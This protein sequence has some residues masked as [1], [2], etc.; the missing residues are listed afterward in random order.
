MSPISTHDKK[1]VNC[2]WRAFGSMEASPVD[3]AQLAA[4]LNGIPRHIHLLLKPIKFRKEEITRFVRTFPEMADLLKNAP[5][6]VML[7]C[8][9]RAELRI[10][11]LQVKTLLAGP[12]R[13]IC[14]ALGGFGTKSELNFLLKI[15]FEAFNEEAVTLARKILGNKAA[16]DAVQL[17]HLEYA[18]NRLLK[19]LTFFAVAFACP[20][21]RKL[22]E[23]FY[24]GQ[25]KPN[26]PDLLQFEEIESLAFTIDDAYRMA[27]HGQ[28]PDAAKQIS[29][30]TTQAAVTQLH[31]RMSIRTQ[32]DRYKLDRLFKSEFGPPPVK[33]NEHII[34]IQTFAELCEESTIMHHCVHSYCTTIWEKRYYVY[35]V[36]APERATLGIRIIQNK[37]WKIDEIKLACNQEPS[38]ETKQVVWEWFGK[39]LSDP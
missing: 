30:F 26:N 8:D 24:G 3:F 1:A 6:L 10:P 5:I 13:E 11:L 38:A 12:R 37:K 15:R 4:F 32:I 31:D 14:K 9:A 20:A 17:L 36:I 33:G 22:V 25:K 21:L 19:L 28:F 18:D 2:A 39:S 34:P 29:S 16:M 23:Q 35:R 27:R 7:L